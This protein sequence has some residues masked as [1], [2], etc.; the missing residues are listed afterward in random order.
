MVSRGGVYYGEGC[1]TKQD[2]KADTTT[3]KKKKTKNGAS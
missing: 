2:I 3:Q 1:E